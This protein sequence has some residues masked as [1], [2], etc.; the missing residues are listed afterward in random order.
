MT[1]NANIIK[2]LKT[3]KV[4]SVDQANSFYKVKNLRARI[5]ECRKDGFAIKTVKN[6][7]GKLAYQLAA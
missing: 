6:T 7:R 2:F 4:L 1:Q 5:D 3:G